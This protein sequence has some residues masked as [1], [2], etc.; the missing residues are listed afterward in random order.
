MAVKPS[1]DKKDR[2]N[3]STQRQHTV[4]TS[5]QAFSAVNM[6][7]AAND[8]PWQSVKKEKAKLLPSRKLR[9]TPTASSR[10]RASVDRGF[11]SSAGCRTRSRHRNPRTNTGPLCER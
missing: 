10:H 11:Y 1:L 2:T 4:K 5:Q 3:S 9:E 8:A 6:P 7:E